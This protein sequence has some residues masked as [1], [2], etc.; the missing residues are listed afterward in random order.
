MAMDYRTK[1][2]LD[3]AARR[4]LGYMTAGRFAGD[5]GMDIDHFDWNPGVGLISLAYYHEYN[6]SP[7]ALEF[8][9]EWMRKNMQKGGVVRAV[10]TTA[11]FRVLFHWHSAALA[12]L[13]HDLSPCNNYIDSKI[14]F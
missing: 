9:K 3:I 2:E 7:A 5:W 11:A 1:T 14:I 12:K 10:N 6:G 8:L 13:V 4:V